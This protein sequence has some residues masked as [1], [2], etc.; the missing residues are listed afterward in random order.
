MSA[1]DDAD[2]RTEEGLLRRWSRRKSD[3]E[4]GQTQQPDVASARDGAAVPGEQVDAL[5]PAAAAKPLP[6]LDSLDEASDYAAFLAAEV[7]EELHR[8]ALRRLFRSPK[9]NVADGLDDYAEDFSTFAPLGNLI[10]QE[11]RRALERERVAQ[12]AA[13]ITLEDEAARGSEPGPPELAQAAPDPSDTEAPTARRAGEDAAPRGDAVA[14]PDAL[15]AD[16][17]PYDKTRGDDAGTT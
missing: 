15:A 7:P 16:A 17:K 2:S 13:E 12:D 5:D 8:L 11:L 14:D 9:F 6:S 3:S 10:T 4:H 1:G